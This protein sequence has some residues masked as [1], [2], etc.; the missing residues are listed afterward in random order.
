M[1]AKRP[2][3][4]G[5]RKALPEQDKPIPYALRLKPATKAYVVANLRS[6][7]A[8]LDAMAAKSKP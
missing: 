3:Y 7:V 8:M 6:I 4:G 2:Y 5:G 1:H